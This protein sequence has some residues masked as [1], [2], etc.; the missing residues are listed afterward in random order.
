MCALVWIASPPSTRYKQKP[1]LIRSDLTSASGGSRNSLCI[2]YF[3]PAK[4]TRRK[5]CKTDR[6]GGGLPHV[7]DPGP[8]TT[9]PL[10]Y[11][12]Q[13]KVKGRKWMWGKVSGHGCPDVI[14]QL[15][16]P[17][18]LEQRPQLIFYSLFPMETPRI[19]R[20]FAGSPL[21]PSDLPLYESSRVIS[22]IYRPYLI[23]ILQ[24]F[25]PF[26]P[27]G[28]SNDRVTAACRRH[29]A[30]WA[31]STNINGRRRGSPA[32]LSSFPRLFPPERAL[33]C[34]YSGSVWVISSAPFLLPFPPSS[35]NW[36]RLCFIVVALSVQHFSG[37]LFSLVL[38]THVTFSVVSIKMTFPDFTPPFVSFLG[39]T[40]PLVVLVQL[41]PVSRALLIPPLP[42]ALSGQ[43]GLSQWHTVSVRCL[44]PSEE[45]TQGSGWLASSPFGENIPALQEEA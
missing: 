18:S 4:S 36:R 42:L 23:Q 14:F 13:K 10:S 29:L 9:S 31:G 22:V 34:S 5:A 26:M 19:F 16:L 30:I 12:L 28:L 8:G 6:T 1:G 27:I 38:M 41:V 39:L 40:L 21:L 37:S 20:T 25:P 7:A 45:R 32:R 43:R 3:L 11:L 44:S 33:F 17:S 35:K 24:I 15:N 2:F